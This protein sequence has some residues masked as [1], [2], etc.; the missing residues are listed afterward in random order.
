[1][2]LSTTYLTAYPKS[3]LSLK[4]HS[5]SYFILDRFNLDFCLNLIFKLLFQGPHLCKTDL[6]GTKFL[7]TFN[8]FVDF[9]QN[10]RDFEELKGLK[11]RLWAG[12]R[13]SRMNL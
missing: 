12:H 10:W 5:Q 7:D 6:L 4:I 3:R 9:S 8:G 2:P 13:C 11:E 1:L